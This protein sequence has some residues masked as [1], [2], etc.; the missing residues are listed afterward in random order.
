MEVTGGVER[1]GNGDPKTQVHTPNLGHPNAPRRSTPKEDRP[2]P[3]R[4]GQE[5][6]EHLQK[7]IDSQQQL[8]GGGLAP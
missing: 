1:Q 8:A 7:E 2:S 6:P 3:G 4:Y 5:E